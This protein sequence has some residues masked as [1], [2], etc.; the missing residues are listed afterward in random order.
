MR[1]QYDTILLDSIQHELIVSGHVEA[2]RNSEKG[3]C[4]LQCHPG[5][6]AN[7]RSASGQAGRRRT[8]RNL[9]HGPPRAG[10]QRGSH[11]L[12]MS[13]APKRAQVL[14]P[15]RT[16]HNT[17]TKTLA[18]SAAPALTVR[19]KP[20][21]TALFPPPFLCSSASSKFR[22][23]CSAPV[24]APESLTWAIL[25][26][27]FFDGIPLELQSVMEYLA[28]A[29]DGE[30]D[31]WIQDDLQISWLTCLYAGRG[32]PQPEIQACKKV[33]GLHP[34]QVWPQILARRIASGYPAATFTEP[35]AGREAETVREHPSPT[36]PPKKPC[37][38][39]EF[40]HRRIS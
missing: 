20:A 30:E 4:D 26:L 10:R 13:A 6:P 23:L 7:C 25:W 27:M 39:A 37:R 29:K 31:P 17:C 21:K 19:P 2:E 3:R 35:V 36:P 1:I 16:K 15:P 11:T 40:R 32:I 8:H 34:H 22:L 18:C 9:P 5:G 38:S 12:I 24:P 14:V 33:L 28:S